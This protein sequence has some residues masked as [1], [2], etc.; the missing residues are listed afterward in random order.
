MGGVA[1]GWGWP[2]WTRSGPRKEAAG[3]GVGA[4]TDVFI[5]EEK[6]E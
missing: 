3:G 5:H 1:I 4:Q 2:P 6:G